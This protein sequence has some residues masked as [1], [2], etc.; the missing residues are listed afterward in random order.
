LAEQAKI[1]VAEAEENNLSFK[2]RTERFTRWHTCSLC[3]QDYHGVVRCAIGWAC[4][5]TY[6]GRPETNVARRSALTQLGNGLSAIKNYE[7]AL[8]VREAELSMERRLGSSEEDI[9]IAHTNL[10]MTYSS[11]GRFEE[12]LQMERDIYS[13][14]V[15]LHGDE[16]LLTLQAANNYASSIIGLKRFEEAKSLLRKTIL[17]ARR[18]LGDG[19]DV[20]LSLRANYAMA[21]YEDPGATLHDL[22]EAVNT[23]E[24]AERIARR[25]LG[26]THPL[27]VNIESHLRCAREI[28]R[29]RDSPHT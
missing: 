17:V 4:W 5:K 11:L 6:L 12:A 13:G 19:N 20:T 9:F 22:R 25:L 7:D 1:L 16:H 29:E 15:K 10:A 3:E 18:V 27:L 28:L 24:D 14:R 2:V 21:L 8:S 23:F 26:G